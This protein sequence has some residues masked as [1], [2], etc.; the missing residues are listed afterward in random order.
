MIQRGC[1]PPPDYTTGRHRTVPHLFDYVHELLQATGIDPNLPSYSVEEHVSIVERYYNDKWPGMYRIVVFKKHGSYRPYYKGEYAQHDVCIFHTGEHFDGVRQPSRLFGKDFYCIDCE[2]PFHRPAT[3]RN[4]CVR[5][6]SD[7]GRMGA[8]Y[9]CKPDPA[10]RK[11]CQLCSKSF[12]NDSCYQHHLKS[13]MCRTY[14]K[15]LHCG[16][17]YNVDLVKRRSPTGRHECDYKFCNFCYGYH[18]TG[19]ECYIQPLQPAKDKKDDRFVAFDF[20]C[21]QSSQT[22]PHRYEHQVIFYSFASLYFLLLGQLHLCPCLLH[23]VHPGRLVERHVLRQVPN[24]RTQPRAHMVRSRRRH[25]AQGLHQVVAEGT[26][27]RLPHLRLLSLRRA[28]RHGPLPRR[29][30]SF[31]LDSPPLARCLAIASEG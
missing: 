20:E 31:S 18:K 5:R 14:H 2:K 11:R 17:A 19:R 30:V 3:H 24:M 6:C 21:S 29:A 10:Y 25:T 28:I 16:V 7:C 8:D 15:C 22:S 23:Q 4:Q 13:R 27:L 1:G 12:R 9:P 26:Q